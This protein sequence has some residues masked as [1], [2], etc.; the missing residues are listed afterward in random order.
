[1]MMVY[2]VRSTRPKFN[3]VQIYY[4]NLQIN[5]TK[6]QKSFVMYVVALSSTGISAI[7]TFFVFLQEIPAFVTPAFIFMINEDSRMSTPATILLFGFLA[8]YFNR[9]FIYSSLIRGGKPTPLII[10]LSALFFCVCNGYMQ[11]CFKYYL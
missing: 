10:F 6:L 11:V 9:T 8:H 2:I 7:W 3:T 1:M 5:S 4:N